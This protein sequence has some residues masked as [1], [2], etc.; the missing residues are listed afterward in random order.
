MSEDNRR[1]ADA[2][3][4]RLLVHPLTLISYLHLLQ[5]PFLKA[6][7]S[8]MLS[9]TNSVRPPTKPPSTITVSVTNL[10]LPLFSTMCKAATH[11]YTRKTTKR[12]SS[13]RDLHKLAAW[14]LQH[15][16]KHCCQKALPFLLFKQYWPWTPFIGYKKNIFCRKAL[17]SLSNNLLNYSIASLASDLNWEHIDAW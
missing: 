15:S 16:I 7:T 8:L 17:R 1:E 4:R 2:R 9:T 3:V 12:N 14:T 10:S 6:L 5:G 13:I 11:G